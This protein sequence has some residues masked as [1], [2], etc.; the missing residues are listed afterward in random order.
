MLKKALIIGL[1]SLPFCF[2][3]VPSFAKSGTGYISVGVIDPTALNM[4]DA[5]ALCEQEPHMVKCDIVR[6]QIKAERALSSLED[7]LYLN[8]N[9]NA[10]LQS[11]DM[12]YQI[13]NANY[14]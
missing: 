13:Y 4:E 2:G 7:V 11:I 3:N 8:A 5:I 1:M 12:K 14:E 6:E 10:V 9:D